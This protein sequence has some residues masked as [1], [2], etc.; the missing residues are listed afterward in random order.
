MKIENLKFALILKKFVSSLFIEKNLENWIEEEK[1]NGT[2]INKNINSYPRSILINF[3]T[4]VVRKGLLKKYAISND[5]KLLQNIVEIMTSLKFG[6]KLIY[7]NKNNEIIEYDNFNEKVK[8][9]LKKFINQNLNILI[10]E[11][12]KPECFWADI[13]KNKLENSNNNS[14]KVITDAR[15][16][17]EFSAV[18][19]IKNVKKVLLI[20][21]ENINN[22]YIYNISISKE[23]ENFIKEKFHTSDIKEV[24]NNYLLEMYNEISSLEDIDNF[25]SKVSS[26]NNK[27]ELPLLQIAEELSTLLSFHYFIKSK[28]SSYNKIVDEFSK[29]YVDLYLN[30]IKGNFED[31]YN[32]SDTVKNLIQDNL[33]LL[34]APS[35]CGKDTMLNFIELQLKNVPLLNNFNNWKENKEIL[36]IIKE[37]KEISIIKDKIK[38]IKGIEY[39]IETTLKQEFENFVLF[40]IDKIFKKGLKN[41]QNSSIRR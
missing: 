25:L 3:G 22:E 40:K 16:Q 32:K 41:V 8:T 23:F 39:L 31:F 24:A 18:E 17:T 36:Q 7:K 10:D 34:I 35:K 21:V 38:K 6:E 27:L 37:N 33:I 1:D 29:D 30:S 12:K 26:S 19:N 28:Y 5:E 4:E 14:F 9:N 2:C 11:T 20:P 13:L 15:F